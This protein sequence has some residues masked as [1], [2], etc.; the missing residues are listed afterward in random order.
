MLA[1]PRSP[2]PA[3]RARAAARFLLLAALVLLSGCASSLVPERQGLVMRDVSFTLHDMR[4]PSGLRVLVERDDRTSLVGLFLVVGAGSTSDPAGKEGLAH[5][6]EHVTFRSRPF[7]KYTFN[8]MLEH[9]GA[10]AWNAFTGL[11][12]TVYFE[13]APASALPALLR[14]EGRRMLAPVT[15]ISQDALATELH[16]VQN[17]LRERNETGFVGEVI[18]SLQA[19]VFPDGHPYKR[20]IIGT[21]QSLSTLGPDDV[22]AFLKQHY[23]PDNMT[24]VILGNV[25]P[26]SAQ[27]LLRETLPR[28]LLAADSPVRPAPR[29][30]AAAPSPPSVPTARLQRKEA[31]VA[32]PELWIG[33]SLPRSFDT[34][35]HLISFTEH[36]VKS[37]STLAIKNDEDIASIN[38]EV[39][40]GVEASMLLCRVRLN[41]GEHPARSLDHVLEQLARLWEPTDSLVALRVNSLVAPHVKDVLFRLEQRRAV[42]DMVRGAE[43]LI[44]RGVKRAILAHFSPDPDLYGRSFRDVMALDRASVTDYGLRYLNRE[45]AHAV[46]FIPPARGAAATPAGEDEPRAVA[47][48]ELDEEEDT[49][50]IS[51]DAE[52]LRAIAPGIGASNYRQ[53]TLPNGLEVIL[54]SRPGLPLVAAGLL[55]HGGAGEAPDPAAAEAAARLAL[56]RDHAHGDPADFGGDMAWVQITDQKRY[57]IQGAAGNVGIMLAVLAERVQSMRVKE[58]RWSAFQHKMVPFLYRTEQRPEMIAKRA[59]LGALLEGHPSGRIVISN[60]LAAT[61]ASAATAWIEAT[62]VPHN[63][64]LAVVGEIDPKLV[65]AIVREQ[66]EGWKDHASSLPVPPPPSLS[67]ASGAAPRFLVTHRPAATQSQVRFGCL[68]PAAITSAIDTRHDVSARLIGDRLYHELRQKL[69][70]TYGFLAHATVERGGTAYLTVAGAVESGKLGPALVVLRD[71]LKALASAPAPDHVIARAKL[72]TAQREGT[73]FM[74]NETIVDALLSSRNVGFGFDRHDTYA[75]ELDAVTAEAIEQDFQACTAGRPTLSIVGDQGAAQA[76][77]REAW[78]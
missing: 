39:V 63:A 24:L 43:D 15:Q 21:H 38:T 53:F 9:A 66:F 42:V 47:P 2:L 13:I 67:R 12:A 31:A 62:H 37:A 55:L 6:V 50:P 41:H 27:R 74:T 48:P 44:E 61:S 78:P 71:T 68:L 10:G 1:L 58:D 75:R 11:D 19:A 8:R 5:Y 59:F 52:R 33:W 20:P 35:A 65:E 64:V 14:L 77:L 29:M 76:A 26:N 23:R 30:P 25:D 4:Y 60:D 18:S 45:R 28:T 56:P 72:R 7:G 22:A 17:E 16:I 51:A 32:T 49:R 34:N 3:R 70:I 36:A 40:P 46:L 73:R 57:W 69:G 54:G